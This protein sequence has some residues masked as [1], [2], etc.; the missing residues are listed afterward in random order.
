MI[1][2]W[3]LIGAIPYLTVRILFIDI[4]TARRTK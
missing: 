1:K 2:G 3:V 4:Y